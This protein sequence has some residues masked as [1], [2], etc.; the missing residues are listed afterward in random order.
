MFSSS[1]SQEAGCTGKREGMRGRGEK[2]MLL[3]MN[4][5]SDVCALNRYFVPVFTVVEEVLRSY[6]KSKRD[7]TLLCKR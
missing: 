1:S 7:N 4:N 5:T 6:G 2:I 3:Q